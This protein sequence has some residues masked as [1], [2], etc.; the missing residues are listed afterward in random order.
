MA[1]ILPLGVKTVQLRI[2]DLEG[3]ALEQELV[4]AIALAEQHDCRL[5][6]NDY[7]QDAIRLGAYGVHLG[8][9]DIETAD[10]AAIAKAGLRLGVSTHCYYE[11]ARARA[12]KPSYMAI[13]P[14]FETQTKVMRFGPQGLERLRLW[15]RCLVGELVAIAG[16]KLHNAGEVLA[17]GA[18]SIAVITAVTEAP[19]PEAAVK[20]WLKLFQNQT[21]KPKTLSL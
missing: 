12:L 5:F 2:K 11:V 21:P 6:I 19:D 13:G 1:R 20:Q 8:Q 9:E 17:A 3:E 14:I 10:L 7:W 15:R 18:D 16:I 4:A